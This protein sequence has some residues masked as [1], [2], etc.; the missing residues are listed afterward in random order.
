MSWKANHQKS[1]QPEIPKN[2]YKSGY[3]PYR[4][5]DNPEPRLSNYRQPKNSNQN[6]NQYRYDQTL[7]NAYGDDYIE[8]LPIP[9]NNPQNKSKQNQSY[10]NFWRNNFPRDP[11]PS[12]SPSPFPYL[13][14]SSTPSPS[15]SPK[16][17]ASYRESQNFVYINT[18]NKNPYKVNRDRSNRSPSPNL[19]KKTDKKKYL[20]SII[21]VILL[22]LIIL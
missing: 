20:F 18:P 9:I 14:T 17:K 6:Q 21:I 19:Y 15:P 5:Y 1:T 2:P 12:K 13:S 7:N 11:S 3:N 16:P 22:I 4:F 8:V 10:A